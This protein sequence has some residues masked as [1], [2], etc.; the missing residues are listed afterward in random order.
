M[1]S[2]LTR[3]SVAQPP[4]TKEITR[5]WKSYDLSVV[6]FQ[7]ATMKVSSVQSHW[8]DL[9]QWFQQIS[10]LSKRTEKCSWECHH[11]TDLSKWIWWALLICSANHKTQG[12]TGWAMQEEKLVLGLVSSVQGRALY[13]RTVRVHQRDS[14]SYG[15]S[16]MHQLTLEVLALL[17]LQV[18]VQ[19]RLCA[20]L[21]SPSYLFLTCPHTGMHPNCWLQLSCHR[22]SNCSA[23]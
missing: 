20:L 8:P 12:L 7:P 15:S 16:F 22:H 23:L 3:G 21:S 19:V 6:K 14:F 10:V 4:L 1:F 13:Q 5:S 11:H 2:Y 9:L 18:Q 17:P